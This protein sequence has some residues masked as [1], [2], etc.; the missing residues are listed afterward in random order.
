M[1]VAHK[2]DPAKRRREAYR[3]IGDQ[4]DDIWDALEH[5]K[6]Q[7]IDI[8]PKATAGLANIKAIKAKFKK[9]TDNGAV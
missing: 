7:G 3:T 1:K 6:Q 2:S 8:G 9:G 4:L 5:I